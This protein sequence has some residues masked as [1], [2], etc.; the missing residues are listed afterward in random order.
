M[1]VNL[2]SFIARSHLKNK[3]SMVVYTYDPRHWEVEVGGLNSRPA[4]A[5]LL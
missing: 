1:P 4:R 3:P 2:A 5:K